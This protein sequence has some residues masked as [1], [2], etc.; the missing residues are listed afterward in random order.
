MMVMSKV[1]LLA[2]VAISILQPP[3]K[4]RLPGQV[5]YNTGH[6]MIEQRDEFGIQA[7]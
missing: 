5:Y 7:E 4:P 3:A 1:A 6:G 2:V